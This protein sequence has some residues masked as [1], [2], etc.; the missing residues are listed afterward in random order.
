MFVNIRWLAARQRH[1]P[2]TVRAQDS[3]PALAPLFFSTLPPSRRVR[4]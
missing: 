1:T 3:R 2:Q 4:L